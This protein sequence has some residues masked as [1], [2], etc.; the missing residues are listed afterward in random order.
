MSEKLSRK[1]LR[2]PDEFQVVAGRAME[3]IVARQKP[4][5]VGL[6]ALVV[7][8]AAAWAIDASVKSR[9]QRAGAALDQ[10]VALE[11]RP[12]AGEGFVPPGAE[13]FASRE[14]RSRAALAALEKV[15]SDAPSTRAA[16]TALAELG[17]VKLKS[18]DAAGAAQALRDYLEQTG[19]GEVLRAFAVESLGYAL[20]AQGKLDEAR[21]AFARLSDE[22]APQRA[23]FQQAR[24]ALVQG[25]PEAKQLLEQVAKDYP[26]DPVALEAQ[27]R[28]ELAAL[29]P[30]PPPGTQPQAA[31]GAAAKGK[32]PP[33]PVAKKK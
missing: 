16:R 4:I 28:V 10:A 19:K 3:W 33:K 29:P 24:L 5:L 1:E 12:I 22:G 23:A 2:Q 9:E 20:E 7:A 27:Q 18:G 6:G 30:P 11:T 15:R 8:L 14:E 17:F 26:K 25:K 32:Q 31:S 21:A 13:T